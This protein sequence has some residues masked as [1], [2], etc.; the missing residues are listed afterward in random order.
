MAAINNNTMDDGK[1]PLVGAPEVPVSRRTGVPLH[2]TVRALL[3]SSDHQEQELGLTFV[4]KVF[5]LLV[6]QYTAV[7]IIVSPFCLIDSFKRFISPWTIPLGIASFFGICFSVYL[8]V[9]RGKIMSVARISLFS[10]TFCFAIGLGLKLSVAPWSNYA[11]VALGQ[12]TT[13]VALLHAVLQFDSQSLQWL[14][15]RTGG[16]LCLTMTGLWILLMR[17]SGSSWLISTAVP[18]GGWLYVLTV[19]KSVRTVVGHREPDDHIR[20]V[21]FILGPP[22]PTCLIPKPR[23][24]RWETVRATH[25]L[26]VFRKPTVAAA[27]TSDETPQTNNATTQKADYGGVGNHVV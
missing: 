10:M 1:E 5:A 6:L 18:L 14:N 15:I 9:T 25:Y 24:S 17:E 22:I 26:G 16:L 8:V 21:I 23:T 20:A 4:R 12:A 2:K 19:F 11:L 3:Q 13:N 7:L 27:G